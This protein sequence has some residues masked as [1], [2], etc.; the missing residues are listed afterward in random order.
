MFEPK[1]PTCSILLDTRVLFRTAARD[2]MDVRSGEQS[3]RA[4]GSIKRP[5]SGASRLRSMRSSIDAW[6]D[7]R[8]E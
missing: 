4:L 6:F 1:R 2:K 8:F 3:G 7:V 5:S